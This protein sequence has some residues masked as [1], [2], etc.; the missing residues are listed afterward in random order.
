MEGDQQ[1]AFPGPC[2]ASL[3]RF[4]ASNQESWPASALKATRANDGQALYAGFVKPREI[5]HDAAIYHMFQAEAAHIASEVSKS[6]DR[7]V[8]IPHTKTRTVQTRH[9]SES[10]LRILESHRSISEHGHVVEAF[11][12]AF[13][14]VLLAAEGFD[15][16]PPLRRG[17]KFDWLF[18][19]CCRAT[20][21]SDVV[22]SIGLPEIKEVLPTI[23]TNTETR[24][25]SGIGLSAHCCVCCCRTIP[26]YW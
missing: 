18:E 15:D 16:M 10:L 6:L 19:M 25:E 3:E 13:L 5:A 9:I 14:G 1:W 24:S 21:I 23:E 2:T 7:G 12:N 4:F 26:S 17:A 20:R 11:P 8:V 22:D